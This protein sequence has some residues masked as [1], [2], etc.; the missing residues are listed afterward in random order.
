MSGNHW[1]INSDSLYPQ[2]MM[3]DLIRL[4]DSPDAKTAQVGGK[5]AS[6][7]TLINA[8]FNVPRG[9]VLGTNF[10]VDWNRQVVDLPEWRQVCSGDP[11]DQEGFTASCE[12]LKKAVSTFQ[13]TQKQTALIAEECRS[14]GNTTFAV[15]SSSPE[16]DLLDSSFAGLY[17]SFLNLTAL[18]VINAIHKCYLSCL[19]ARVFIY[20]HQ[21]KLASPAPSIAVIVQVQVN[22]DI[23]GVAFSLNPINNDYDEVLINAIPGSGEA[24]VSGLITPDSWTVEKHT[25][26]LLHQSIGDDRSGDPCLE[27]RQVN[28]IAS[29]LG[30]IES[31]GNEPVDIEWAF[32][33]GELSLLQ[34]R[35]IT[36]Y[37]PL[38]ASMQTEPGE[39]R[40]LF[41]DPSLADGI[42][43][44]GPVSRVTNDTIVYLISTLIFAVTNFYRLDKPPKKGFLFST[45]TRLY[46][47]FSKV[48]SRID[49]TSIATTKDFIDTTI[50]EIVETCDLSVYQMKSARMMPRLS[51]L[52]LLFRIL[53]RF[54]TLSW[55]FLAAYF[56]RKKF[57]EHYDKT[58]A[59]FDDFLNQPIPTNLNVHDFLHHYYSRLMEVTQISTA[60]ALGL[61]IFAGTN[62]FGSV[63]DNHSPEQ[64][65]LVEQIKSGAEDMV[66]DMGIALHRLAMSLDANRFQNLEKLR[67]MIL[68]R[69]LDLEFMQQWDDFQARF[70]CRGALEMDLANP[71]YGDDPM[72]ALKQIADLAGGDRNF[73]PGAAHQ[74]LVDQRPIAFEKLKR[75]LSPQNQRRLSGSFNIMIAF[76]KVREKPK[77][78]LVKINK[79]FREYLLITAETWMGQNRLDKV[80]DIFDMTLDEIYQGQQSTAFNIHHALDNR[81]AY[82]TRA[83]RVL[84]FPHFIDSR[85][86]IIRPLR[87]KIPGQLSGVPLSAGVIS[88]PVKVLHDPFEKKLLPGD[89]LVAHTTDPGWTPLFINAAAVLLEV[90]GE[91]QHGALVAREYGKPCIAGIVNLMNDL[92]D[93]QMVEV[94]G[95]SGIVRLL[96]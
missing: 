66:L 92:E 31:L 83:K 85:G 96:S 15:R 44:S 42:T 63:I 10:F 73:D 62:R 8:G 43:I 93:G 64:S 16:E 13:L 3:Q 65:R 27:A 75:Q 5:A 54:R 84:H 61:Y 59:E 29:K 47:N 48:M 94:E 9:F 46:L 28:E 80:D 20:K 69:S 70:G 17:E 4:S 52:P 45:G 7:I 22:S 41:L 12:E 89:I 26:R 53:W 67:E 88:G 68:D 72:V 60:P 78:H 39:K 58:I 56:R 34:A 50:A 90:G 1:T 71:K 51:S 30:E 6:L 14:L 76:E 57:L 49:I 37:I 79:R 86:R 74:K 95:N 11:L 19:D 33:N 32:A 91:L 82:T 23:S 36:T 18:E 35:P 25:N 87:E 2:S 40:T 24:L 38:P 55:Y 81:D 21:M 77:D